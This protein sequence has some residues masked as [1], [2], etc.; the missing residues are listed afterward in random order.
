MPHGHRRQRSEQRRV[1]VLGAGVAGLTAAHE[2]IQRDYQVVVIEKSGYPGGKAAT[3]YPWLRFAAEGDAPG[4][5]GQ[6]PAEHGFRL[7][8]TFYKHVIDTMERTP[9]DRQRQPALGQWPLPA[10]RSPL[11]LGRRYDSVADNLLPTTQAAMARQG[12]LPRP[13]QLA[14]GSDF[15]GYLRMMAAGSPYSADQATSADLERYALRIVQYLT[16]CA[17]R[18]DAVDHP[19]AY[20]GKTWWEFLGGE[21][22]SPAFQREIDSFTRTMIAMD[23]RRGNARTVGNI[24]MQLLLDST[25]DGGRCDRVLNGPTSDQWLLPWAEYLQEQGVRFAYNAFVLGLE[26]DAA[27]ARLSGV[28]C[29]LPGGG[30]QLVDADFVVST[31][32]LD[33]MGRLLRQP[34]SQALREADARLRWIADVDL[35]RYTA[36]LAGVQFYLRRDLPVVRGHVYYPE[37]PW[38]LSSVSQ[39]QFWGPDFFR[40][41]A[42]SRYRGILSVDVADWDHGLGQHDAGARGRRAFECTR[43][44]A[45]SEIWG[46]LRAALTTADGALLPERV[47]PFWFDDYIRFG[48]PRAGASGA[49]AASS[50]ARNDAVYFVPPAG[51]HR[52]RPGA[53]APH[54]EPGVKN[55]LLAGDYVMTETDLATMEAAN[56]AGRRAVNAI[57]DQDSPDRGEHCRLWPLEEP[58]EYASMKKL[59]EDLFNR[60]QPHLFEAVDAFGSIDPQRPSSAVRAAMRRAGGVLRSMGSGPGGPPGPARR[61]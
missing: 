40:L 22:F 10:S 26:H 30:Q 32:P 28:R 38:K 14:Y 49:A 61:G 51:S 50:P 36:W 5:Y 15:R 57:L 44:Q 19:Y 56:E 59:D 27:G 17:Q 29:Q 41:Y 42:G 39:A 16:S 20:G 47:P 55:L 33:V 13:I 35:L 31:L 6:V 4:G 34:G 1:C 11:R 23:A 46:Q 52:Q 8:P 60:G 7:F 18:R 12:H 3:Q 48:E 21:R 54:G 2:L 45:A 58:P 43:E 37:A 53:S 25:T 9:F 24:G